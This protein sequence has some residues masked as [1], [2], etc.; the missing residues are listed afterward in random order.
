MG[1]MK[2]AN[3]KKNANGG[4]PTWL[5]SLIVGL[6]ALLVVGTCLASFVGST[7]VIGRF[8]T[9]MKT[10]NYSINKPMM[11]YFY[12]T[13]YS[14][15]VSGQYYQSLY[16]YCSLNNAKNGNSGLPLNEQKIGEG[17]YD[18]ILVS[19]ISDYKD[20]TWHDY[21]M[22]QALATAKEVLIF[23]EVADERGISLTDEEL[24]SV[25]TS[26]KALAE[27]I[28]VSKDAYG[29][30]P[31]AGLSDNAC[32]SAAF[33][34]GVKMSDVKNALE[35]TMLASKAQ[36]D[37]AEK[38][39]DGVT[40][41]RINAE[42]AENPKHYDLVDYLTFSF[43]VKY[44]NVVK[45]VLADIGED[46]KEEDHK[47]EILAAYK[48]EIA[49]ASKKAAELS[50]ITDKDEFLK[51]ILND[52][53]TENYD[54]T[55]DEVKE[56][57]K[58]EDKVL[59]SEEDQAKIKDAMI[60]KIFEELFAEDAKSTA[61]DDVEE[62]DDKFYAYD[63][64]INKLYGEFLSTLKSDLYSALYSL[65]KNAVKEEATYTV[66]ADEKDESEKQKWLYSEDRK[67][68]DI[69][70]IEDG[71]GAKGAEVTAAT[72]KSYTADV[73]LMTAPR[74]KDEAF[75]RNGAYMVF[76]KEA[77]AKAAIEALKAKG[78][79]DLDAFLA[80]AAEKADGGYSELTDYTEGGLNSDDLDAWLF[81]E[82]RAKGD[83]S[84]EPVAVSSSF[85][86]AYFESVGEITGWQ[87]DV[88]YTLYN[89]DT[90]AALEEYT[91]KYEGSVV[92]KDK[93]LAKVGK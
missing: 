92:L 30:T 85:V 31:Y 82:K 84:A 10:D 60:A 58:L 87:A 39:L 93:V 50:A 22:D 7:G 11:D 59:P 1:K 78:S 90:T 68:G 51:Y 75:V 16:S 86:V 47:D 36:N 15:F 4:V 29:T 56:E 54:E 40:I 77:D 49:K 62:K 66:P 61:V 26:A 19:N 67:A 42:Y 13:S 65:K 79:V 89:E 34:D 76:T 2:I 53:L 14:S 80:V 21:F 43:S 20:K 23:C 52:H 41:D 91:E 72:D 44:D 12:Q 33:G 46:A 83:F 32:I 73:L 64:E 38:A 81:D 5:L 63:V 57:K 48:E 35:L 6:V 45:E 27:Q 17:Q 9:A 24:D 8:S 55:Y 37:I 70:L 18:S 88:K 74:Y 69:T 25:N 3:N 28:R 71:D